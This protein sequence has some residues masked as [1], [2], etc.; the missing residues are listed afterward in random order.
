MVRFQHVGKR[1]YLCAGRE[2]E[3][4]HT[5]SDEPPTRLPVAAQRFWRQCL[6]GGCSGGVLVTENRVAVGFFRYYWNPVTKVLSAAGTW[7]A[8]THR[9]Q[10]IARRCWDMVLDKKKPRI[11]EVYTATRGGKKLVDALR[12]TRRPGLRWAQRA[13]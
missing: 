13:L 4:D 2:V 10:G 12:A 9:G 1:H 3:E 5:W 11:V 6:F 8:K 7:V